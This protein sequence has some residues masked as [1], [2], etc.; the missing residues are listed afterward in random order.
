MNWKTFAAVLACLCLTGV[1]ASADPP[2]PPPAPPGDDDVAVDD[3]DGVDIADDGADADEAEAGERGFTL[4]VVD[5]GEG[6]KRRLRYDLDRIAA[7]GPTTATVLVDTDMK[8][9]VGPQSQRVITP[10]IRMVTTIEPG[11][12]AEDGGL[13]ITFELTEVSAKDRPGSEPGMAAK[14]NMALKTMRGTK[15]TYTLLP[16][17]ETKDVEVQVPPG[18]AAAQAQQHVDQ[19]R[20][21]VKTM[22]MPLPDE[23]VGEG[24]TWKFEMPLESDG[25]K[26]TY[27]AEVTLESVK[28][29]KLGLSM[30]IKQEAEA[31]E[32]INAQGQQVKLTGLK[33]SG[34]GK[35]TADLAGLVPTTTLKTTGTMTMEQAGQ[36]IKIDIDADTKVT[37]D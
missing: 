28:G 3:I 1:P 19:L 4:T 11:E 16:N 14:M 9:S 18:V 5:A 7:G 15:G 20:Q 37:G 23:K 12:V 30:S 2:V 13:R 8:V 36:A 29:D 34:S 6:E 26:Q 32:T 33:L 21:T 22:S 27:A 24:A 25:T 35:Q 31:A 10:T 17:G